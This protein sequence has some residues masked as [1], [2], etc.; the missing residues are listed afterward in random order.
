MTPSLRLVFTLAVFAPS[1]IASAPQMTTVTP[2]IRDTCHNNSYYYRHECICF[3]DSQI[4]C[5]GEFTAFLTVDAAQ[6]IPSHMLIQCESTSPLPEAL[7]PSSSTRTVVI[8]DCT[9]A[10]HPLLSKPALHVTDFSIYC[11]SGFEYRL[12][13]SNFENLKN[14]KFLHIWC[15][16]LVSVSG[17]A[18]KH[19]STALTQLTIRG[20][21]QLET[22]EA[23]TFENLKRLTTLK[24]KDN[25]NLKTLPLSVFAG[26]RELRTLSLDRNALNRLPM[27]IFDG[28]EKLADL[29]IMFNSL[30]VLEPSNH[31][32]IRLMSNL[33]DLDPGQNYFVDSNSD[34]ESLLKPL[35]SLKELNLDSNILPRLEILNE[36]KNLTRISVQNCSLNAAGQNS[37]QE[38]R[39]LEFLDLSNNSI[40]NLPGG[41]LKPSSDKLQSFTLTNNQ[42]PR[43]IISEPTFEGLKFL[44]F[45]NL[46]GAALQNIPLRAF[47]DLKNLKIIDMSRNN[48]QELPGDL[49]EENENVEKISLSNN[50]FSVLPNDI[51]T[52]LTN[53]KELDLSDNSLSRIPSFLF[54]DT[55]G[56]TKLS[57]SGNRIRSLGT[58][59]LLG[60]YSVQTLDI[61]DNVLSSIDPDT[62][63]NIASSKRDHY[64]YMDAANNKAKTRKPTT[65]KHVNLAKNALKHLHPNIFSTLN[66]METLD[67]SEN[68]LTSLPN[69]HRNYK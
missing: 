64:N 45:L 59:D 8:T 11:R 42:V 25:P 5:P 60:L 48:I 10:E 26:L 1:L 37:L 27:H 20:S 16:S 50:L 31:P 29:S 18:F 19:V 17:N 40:T 41:F 67:L 53:L 22:I 30:L 63:Y 54:E 3:S 14:L 34:T 36:L 9:F 15:P 51:F 55:V 6:T 28:L 33:S 57:L 32:G 56:V 43:F 2:V 47:K 23:R 35:T 7:V 68:L 49:F 13:S 52:N 24:I 21:Q 65:L 66:L 4:H 46:S 38:L 44:R 69:L 58:Y 12:F 61:S 39:F 62:M